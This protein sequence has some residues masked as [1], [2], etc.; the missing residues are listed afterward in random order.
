[1]YTTQ[2]MAK[3]VAA[4]EKPFTGAGALAITALVAPAFPPTEVTYVSKREANSD[5]GCSSA[6]STSRT[7]PTSAKMN[8]MFWIRM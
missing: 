6:A 5:C 3:P 1:M 2:S 8:V 4:I 7:T